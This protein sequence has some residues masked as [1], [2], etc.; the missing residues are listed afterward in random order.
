MNRPN[1]ILDIA[2]DQGGVVRRD[3]ALGV[4]MTRSKIAH[5]L[6]SGEWQPAG[7]GGYRVFDMKGKRN[8]VKAA[9]AV[10]PNAVAS[11]FSAAALL[12]ISYVPKREV[13]VT[14]DSKTTHTFPGVRVFRNQD[15]ATDHWFTH[16][17]IPTTTVD[18]TVLDLA[19]TMHPKLLARSI[20]ELFAERRCTLEGLT[21]ILESVARRGKPGVSNLRSVLED[22]G[23]DGTS[24]TKLERAGVSLLVSFGFTGFV[25]EYPIPWTD[26]K[27]FDVAF[28]LQRL[29]IEWDSYRWHTQE[30]RFRA[31]RERDRLAVEH[32]WR[33]LRFAWHDVHDTPWVVVE[34]IRSVLAT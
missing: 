21:N 32:G 6:R 8:L 26:D 33:T 5:R 29:A 15:M 18:R 17:G 22:R 30:E 25:R 2:N 28:P 24:G 4:G 11:H 13:S 16:E 27:R 20:D 3:Q 31:D 14:V 7:R 34:S 19:A 12:D 10:L 9:T 23:E 1:T